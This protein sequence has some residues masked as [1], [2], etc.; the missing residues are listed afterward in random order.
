MGGSVLG[1]GKSG[2][3]IF[4]KMMSF[5]RILMLSLAAILAGGYVFASTLTVNIRQPFII[6]GKSYPAGHYRIIAED[7]NDHFVNIRNLDTETKFSEIRFD[8][9]ISERKGESGSVVFDKVGNDLYL[10]E[11]YFIGI[12]GFF[13][14]GAP[15]KHKQLAVKE[16]ID[17]DHSRD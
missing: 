10:A 2:K 4:M 7:E 11:I 6:E 1:L 14:K 15:G 5:P 12:D 16:E 3:E 17:S 8:T 9:R 13:F